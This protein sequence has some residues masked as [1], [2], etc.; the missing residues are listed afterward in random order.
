MS[1]QSVKEDKLCL[2]FRE[3]G[4]IKKHLSRN[5]TW[6]SGSILIASSC[7]RRTKNYTRLDILISCGLLKFHYLVLQAH[8]S[9]QI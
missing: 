4:L 5:M 7:P 3:K 6:L 2:E 1:M 8:F 9:F